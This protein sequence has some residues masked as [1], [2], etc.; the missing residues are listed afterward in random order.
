MPE[1]KEYENTKSPIAK[2][3]TISSL[4]SNF[5]IQPIFSVEVCRS[6]YEAMP[7]ISESVLAS[8]KSPNNPR[9]FAP[10][11]TYH[12]AKLSNEVLYKGYF[13][14]IP[15]LDP[16]FSTVMAKLMESE[17]GAKL[18]GA[19]FKL[20]MSLSINQIGERELFRQSGNRPFTHIAKFPMPGLSERI[21]LSEWLGLSLLKK[22]SL[23]PISK[24]QLASFQKN[25]GEQTL[26]SP[27]KARLNQSSLDNLR[28]MV[29]E[30][31][32]DNRSTT[33]QNNRFS[34]PFLL[35]ERFDVTEEGSQ[36]KIVARDFAC[37]LRQGPDEK[38][39]SSLESIGIWIQENIHDE[40]ERKQISLNVFLQAVCSM[41]VH[42]NDLHLKNLTLL[43]V[44]DPK[45]GKSKFQM[46]PVYDVLV[47]PLVISTNPAYKQALYVNQSHFPSLEDYVVCGN[48]SFGLSREFADSLITD[49][50]ERFKK[51][52]SHMKSELP[53]EI[54]QNAAW[55]D[56]VLSGLQVVARNIE[57]LEQN[58]CS[59][60]HERNLSI[61]HTM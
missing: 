34:P 3:E 47:T 30:T 52:V 22:V 5:T 20:P 23:I 56:S 39:N 9:Y 7:Q 46:A 36:S 2:L 60:A 33:S 11:V 31:L 51:V 14:G 12:N 29:E 42:N 16:E 41:I 35:S 18:S 53:L 6:I 24:F 48:S 61:M 27:E 32:S 38:Y 4:V 54:E 57:H 8:L 40:R 19:Q 26:T 43:E 17:Y 25:V 13:E 28:D 15:S 50:I 10:C 49:T 55:R 45:E 59:F 37:L 1:P 58:R 44:F 21:T